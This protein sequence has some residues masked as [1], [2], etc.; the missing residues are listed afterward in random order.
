MKTLGINITSIGDEYGNL[1]GSLN[2]GAEVLSKNIKKFGLGNV[3][4]S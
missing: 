1:I 4:G 2:R 3:R